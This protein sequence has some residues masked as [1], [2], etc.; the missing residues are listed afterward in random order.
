[1]HL[2]RPPVTRLLLTQ[3]LFTSL[4]APAW[5]Q[6]SAKLTCDHAL[7][8]MVAEVTGAPADTSIFIFQDR[9]DADDA[10]RRLTFLATGSPRCPAAHGARG[11]VKQRLAQTDWVPKD[12]PGQ[13][14]GIR[15]KEDALYDIALAAKEGGAA[16]VAAA[17]VGTQTLLPD[18]VEVPY[19]VKEIGPTLLDIPQAQSEIPDT[20]R[21]YLRGRLAAWLWR[22]WAADSA[23]SSY[24]A[25]GGSPDR[26]ALELARIRLATGQLGADSLYYRAAAAVDPRIARDLRY[27]I[28]F[29]ADS[30]ELSAFDRLQPASRPAWLQRFWE[31]RDLEDLRPRGSRLREH[32]RRI[33]VA[34]ER[35]RLLSYPRQYELNELWIN[36]H[37]EY[38]D[39]GLV[40]IR[41]GEPDATASAVRA[42]ACPNTSWLY[43]RPEGNLVLHFLARQNPDDWRVVETLANV[44]GESGATTRVR[45]AGASHSCGTV[46]D[47]LESRRSLDPIYAQLAGNQTRRN[48]ERELD[49]TT[50]SREISTTT[51]TDML[52]FP[53]PLN[54]SWRAYGLL[55]NTPRQGRMLVLVSVP[56]TSLAPISQDPLAYGF[57]MRLVG[58]SGPRAFELDSVRQLGVQ[59]APQPGQMVTFTTEVPLEVGTWNVGLALAQQR[60]SAGDVLHDRSVP[61]PDAAGTRLALSDIVLGD[62]TGGRPWA[63]PDGPFPLSPTGSYVRGEPVP[64]YYE[65]AGG[66]TKGDIES[67]VTFVRDDGKGRSTIRFTE[68]A[69]RPV[70]RV[71]RELNTSK[72]Q[73]GRY[74]LTVRIR[75]PDNRRAERQTTLILIPEPD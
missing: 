32:Y 15:W 38:D 45:R 29:V 31:D 11:L 47:L 5:G 69:D 52:R 36:R 28:A 16:A 71:R 67:E 62:A 51:D 21:Y 46:D 17:T 66:G 74:A 49:I 10:L 53:S 1:M 61:I 37:A 12:L 68:R 48:W 42:G 75:T 43:R 73:P 34:R 33:G 24:Q 59:Q 8:L 30:Q 56:A 72:S 57:R 3:L 13:R 7:Q 20:I 18:K 19:L 44:S 54:T 65:I 55:G 4:S 2:S 35:F 50:R 14:V 58:R 22:P 39:R 64:I 70:L 9:S 23:F 6:T 60:D 27:D 26:A 63:A 25:A 41:H 40:Y